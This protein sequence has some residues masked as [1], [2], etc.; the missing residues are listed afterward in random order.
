MERERE[1]KRQKDR[2]FEN[3]SVVR[4][5]AKGP[6][7]DGHTRVGGQSAL[8]VCG[9]RVGETVMPGIPAGHA[10][11]AVAGGGAHLAEL[12]HVV[13]WSV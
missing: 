3:L 9:L 5:P 10:A 13:L 6:Q 8:Q 7:D 4:V 2:D 1:K 12:H 11:L